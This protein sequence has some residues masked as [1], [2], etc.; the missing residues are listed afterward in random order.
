MPARPRSQTATAVVEAEDG[1]GALS[2]LQFHET[3]S[4]RAGKPISVGELLRRLQELFQELKGMEQETV[5]TESL[6]GVAMELANHNILSHK[7][8]GV[9]ARA[10]CCLVE[11]LRLCAPNAPF[12]ATQLKDVF[13]LFVSTILPSLSDPSH[14]YN[15][16]HLHVLSSLAEVK[17]IVLLLDIPGSHDLMLHLFASSFDTLSGA[18]KAKTGEDISKNVEYYLTAMLATLVDESQTL[19]ADIVDIIVAQF[20]RADPS[21]VGLDSGKTKKGKHAPAKD[22][23][24]FTLLYRQLPAAYNMAK[25]ICNECPD[26]MARH[27]GQYFNNVILDASDIT[28]AHAKRRSRGRSSSAV[29][30]EDDEAGHGPSDHELK[31]MQKVH[32]LVR[33]LWR[34][35][36]LTLQYVMPQLEA[37][38]SAEDVEVRALAT[39][40]IG[41]MISG[42]GAAGPPLPIKI[43][44][45]AYPPISLAQLS[46][47]VPIYNPL[48]TPSSPQSFLQVHAAAYQSFMSRRNDR[49]AIVRAYWTTAIGRILMT[50]AGGVA[51][52]T[53]ESSEIAEALAKMFLD[54]DEKVRLAAVRVISCA[55]LKDVVDKVGTMGGVTDEG[56][57]LGNLSDRM[58]DPKQNVRTE[59]M[60]CS[61][62][63]WGSAVG[64]IAEGNDRVASLFASIPSKVLET[65]YVNNKDINTLV[66]RV[67]F[68]ALLPLGYPSTKAKAMQPNGN[69][70]SQESQTG[71]TEATPP[72]YNKVRAERILLLI[73][74]LVPRSRSVFF[75]WQKNQVATA[76]YME[77]FLK[78]CEDYN[79]GVTEKKDKDVKEQ[80]RRLIDFFARAATDAPRVSEDLWKF[81]KMHD[82]RSYQLV[83]FAM[84]PESDYRKVQKA[85]K[86]LL[87]R[88]EEA[89]GN[90]PTMSETVVQLLYKCSLLVYNKSHVAAFLE[91]SK[92][93]EKS[94]GGAAHEVLKE[95]SANH[96]EVF[97]AQ[98]KALC[99][100]IDS[101][102]YGN[103]DA[104][105]VDSL[106]TIAG[107]TKQY[108]QDVPKD[109]KFKQ[110][111]MN[112]ILNGSPAK[113]AKH[114]VT[115]LLESTDKKD[116][117]AQDI[118]RACTKDLRVGSEGCL[119]RLAAL[120]Q[121]MLLATSQLDTEADLVTDIALNQV[122]SRT[123]HPVTRDD[124]ESWTDLPS[125]DCE[126]KV[127]A[128][129]ILVNRVRASYEPATLKDIAQPVF[130][131]LHNLVLNEGELPNSK[132]TS[133]LDKARLRLLA[134]RLTLKLCARK[135]LDAMLT[136]RSFNS[137]ALI[138]QAP[139]QP[140][141]EGF[142]QKLKKYLGR[143]RLSQRFY[144]IIFLLAFEP[145]AN[146]REETLT[147]IRARASIIAKAKD[148]NNNPTL[149]LEKIFTRLLSLLAHH[150]DFGSGPEDLPDFVAYIMFYLKAVAN[151]RNLAVIF[152]AAQRVK[153]VQDGLDPSKS[154]VL[155][156]LSDLAQAVIRRYEEVMGWSMQMFAGKMTLPSEIFRALPS[157]EAAQAIAAKQYLPEEI[158]DRINDLVKENMRTRKV[159][160]LHVFSATHEGC[161]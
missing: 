15:R 44:L 122:L 64:E 136:P 111:L 42:I 137:L 5:D 102:T 65:V 67:L 47:S 73:R 89:S 1:Q 58:K 87:K 94:L 112:F 108:P 124:N 130:Q 105:A 27:I 151:E 68:E 16:E 161:N 126:A 99:Q 118:V 19:A 34:S 156:V 8:R 77:A 133:D 148:S 29:T 66:Y 96:P 32:R 88:V 50:S 41:D 86:E 61:S 97:R 149:A 12:T 153:A 6:A 127:W 90:T 116:A 79:G 129:T 83:R 62:A 123:S 76:K 78:R 155:Y 84:A 115:I 71:N 92:T 20:L 2:R 46:E 85:I 135:D 18:M 141:R 14:A 36:P 9:R 33:E 43:D 140:V 72:D 55:S 98:I 69:P 11:I 91:F 150:P 57:V 154:Q 143:N 159:E 54:S 74:D 39:E 56:S 7:D 95:I 81:A 144:T 17:S 120:S 138:A 132:S 119:S 128:L 51:L 147:W 101:Q 145:N 114:A 22:D 70:T 139:S 109:Q 110:T 125:G 158:L 53:Q 49:T 134:A 104:G 113:T 4:W 142:V 31:E 80:L 160:F 103:N 28:S 13:I 23:R 82:R 63:L 152:H 38:L 26:K 107:F 52:N 59:A 3:L 35:C 37:E 24:Q 60:I 25:N 121:L 106:K 45:A 157:H 131:L 93:D 100:S 75:A 48:T 30:D 117:R 21:S 146:L 10:A 40:T